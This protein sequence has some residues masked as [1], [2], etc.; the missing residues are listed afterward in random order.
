[1][2]GLVL[3]ILVWQEGGEFVGLLIAIGAV[4]LALLAYWLVRRKREGKPTLLDPGLFRFPHF[5]S[6][7]SG[8]LLQNVT[9]GGAMIA[10]PIFLQMTLEYNALK[11]GLTLAPL[12]LSMFAVALLAGRKAGGR[13]PSDIILVGFALSTV[14]IALIIPIVP[15]TDSGWWLFVPLLIT[16]SGLGLLVSQLNNYTLSPIE[17]ERVSEAAG[18]N[19]A[20]GSFGLS[21]GLAVAGGI[22]LAVLAFSFTNLA[23]ESTVIP[24]AQQQRIS[25]TLEDDAEVI[26]NAQLE[27][28]LADEPKDVREEILHINKEARDRSLQVALLVPVLASLLGLLNAFRMRRLPD[29]K[30]ASSAEGVTLG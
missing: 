3:G 24:P 25:D 13:R 26:S 1:M 21:F 9:L 17:E 14:G 11:T 15:R 2:G 6:G 7:I 8:Q 19:S 28:L 18:V 23:E 5:T 29:P 16:G 12:S 22:M 10:L 27:P 4:A 30:P 20:A